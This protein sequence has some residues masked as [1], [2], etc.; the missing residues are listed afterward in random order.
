MAVM[1]AWPFFP[2]YLAGKRTG[3]VSG[4]G[5]SLT[6]PRRFL[7]WWPPAAALI[8][9]APRAV[10]TPPRV[11]PLRK[12]RSLLPFLPFLSGP[13]SVSWFGGLSGSG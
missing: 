3:P 1:Y 8:L 6:T 13:S 9:S 11:V 2:L 4:F 12:L 5:P 7:A 10:L